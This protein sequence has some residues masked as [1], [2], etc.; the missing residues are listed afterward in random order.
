MIIME[1]EKHKA[2]RH[3]ALLS[4]S[5]L[6]EPWSFPS[7]QGGLG[8]LSGHRLQ[9]PLPWT[10]L[11]Q[12]PFS[13]DKIQGKVAAMLQGKRNPFQRLGHFLLPGSCGH[14][15]YRVRNG[16]YQKKQPS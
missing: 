15:G 9:P 13:S 1:N 3:T 14:G 6:S 12:N 8:L 2:W 7:L 10:V 16:M 5:S 11:I 4:F